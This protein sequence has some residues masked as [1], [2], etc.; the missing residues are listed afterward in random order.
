METEVGRRTRQVADAGRAAEIKC[1][2]PG[3]RPLPDHL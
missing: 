3:G 1:Q 2:G